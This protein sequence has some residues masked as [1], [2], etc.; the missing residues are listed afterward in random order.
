MS[1]AGSVLAREQWEGSRTHETEPGQTATYEIN[2]AVHIAGPTQEHIILNAGAADTYQQ[3]RNAIS[4][5]EGRD[6]S[7]DLRR[8]T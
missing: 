7:S 4:N 6:S 3:V 8:W 1:G 2:I 5:T